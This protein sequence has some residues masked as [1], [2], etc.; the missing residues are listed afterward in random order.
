MGSRGWAWSLKQVAPRNTWLR[1]YGG[2]GQQ[3]SRAT[4]SGLSKVS[5]PDAGFRKATLRGTF[6]LA[7]SVWWILVEVCLAWCCRVASGAGSLRQERWPLA[8]PT[9]EGGGLSRWQP[10]QGDE[11][12]GG[13]PDPAP[14]P[15]GGSPWRPSQEQCGDLFWDD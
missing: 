9:V 6:P 10:L 12:R 13:A 4:G 11:A 8:M 1:G 5:L 15:S 2:L 3:G 14:D 7:S